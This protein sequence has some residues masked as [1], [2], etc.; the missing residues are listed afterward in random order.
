MTSI[1]QPVVTV[2]SSH[3]SK[4]RA[5]ALTSGESFTRRMTPSSPESGA[6]G[7]RGEVLAGGAVKLGMA[8]LLSEEARCQVSEAEAQ[9]HEARRQSRSEN[10]SMNKISLYWMGAIIAVMLPALNFEV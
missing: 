9:E 10:F 1:S 5:T 7:W 8:R 4:V 3:M 6:R 2:S